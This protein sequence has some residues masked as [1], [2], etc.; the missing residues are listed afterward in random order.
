MYSNV[1]KVIAILALASTA[2]VQAS[3]FAP[4][5]AIKSGSGITTVT[6]KALHHARL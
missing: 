3:A 4:N 6:A 2:S 1:R 5:P